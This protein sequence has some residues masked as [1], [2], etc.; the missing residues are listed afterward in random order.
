MQ[1]KVWL[2]GTRQRQARWVYLSAWGLRH[3]SAYLSDLTEAGAPSD[4]PVAYGGSGSA[5]S[6]QAAAGWANIARMVHGPALTDA[7]APR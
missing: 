3:L 5:E 1:G 6:Q 7:G 4:T 2:V